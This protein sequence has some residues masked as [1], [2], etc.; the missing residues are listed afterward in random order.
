MFDIVKFCVDMFVDFMDILDRP[1]IGTNTTILRLILGSALLVTLIKVVF[2][3]LNEGSDN[4]SALNLFK[5]NREYKS[6]NSSGFTHM[7]VNRKTGEVRYG[8]VDK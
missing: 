7:M 5:R 4:V 3:G 1:L 6:N 2:A 8:K